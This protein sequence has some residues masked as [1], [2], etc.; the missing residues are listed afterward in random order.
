MINKE[1]ACKLLKFCPTVLVNHHPLGPNALGPKGP[2][3]KLY[4]FIEKEEL[5]GP[6]KINGIP[7]SLHMGPDPTTEVLT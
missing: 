3:F 6:E 5:L 4:K 2:N 7:Q 1:K